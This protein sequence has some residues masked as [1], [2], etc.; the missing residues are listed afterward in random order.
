MSLPRIIS[1]FDHLLHGG[2]YNPDQWQRYPE[3]LAEDERL[4]DRAGLNVVA[5][6]I[7]AWTSYER[8]E[9]EFEFGWLDRAMDALARAGKKVILATPSGA[10]P[11][12]MS[13]KYPEIRRVTRDGLREA[14]TGRHNH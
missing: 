14:H 4:I 7:F 11:V 6:G 2:D 9:D 1:G 13:L 10:K 8:Q 12:W 3:V 5:L